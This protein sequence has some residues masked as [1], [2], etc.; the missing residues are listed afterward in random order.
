MTLASSEPVAETATYDRKAQNDHGVTIIIPP[1]Q[2]W[3]DV[4]KTVFAKFEAEN[5]LPK[6]LIAQ[7]QAIK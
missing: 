6:G 5:I 1:A 2:P 4:A 3:L 7:V